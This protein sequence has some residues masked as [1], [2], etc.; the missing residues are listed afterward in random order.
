MSTT[1]AL[2]QVLKTELKAAGW[3]Y[4][5]LA[6][7]LGLAESSVKRMFARGDMPLARIDAICEVLKTDFTELSRRV[8]AAQ[9]ER[10][11]LTLEQERAVVADRKLL[12][13]AVCCQSQWTLEQVVA[14]YR[15]SETEGIALLAQLDRLGIIELRPHNRYRLKLAKA[16]RWRPHGPV[17]AF[18][19]EQVVGDFFGGGF[20]GEGELLTLVHGQIRPALV[21]SYNDRLQRL[22]QDFA[23]QHLADQKLPPDQK[24]ACT[25]LIGLRSWLFGAFRELRRSGV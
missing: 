13:M 7:E 17:M 12:L 11:E 8:A 19:R 3:T 18:F 5:A 21:A 2:I 15:L 1:Q 14:H 23:Q 16:F 24:Q 10:H 25:L 4:A 20:D 6:R 9:P 22:A